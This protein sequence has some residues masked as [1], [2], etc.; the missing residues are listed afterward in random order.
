MK[1][2]KVLILFGLIV[3]ISCQS[4]NKMEYS[5]TQTTQESDTEAGIDRQLIRK[6]TIAFET[7][8]IDSTRTRIV[9]KAKKL[10]GYIASDETYENSNGGTNTIVIRLPNK[11]FEQFLETTITGTEEVLY[12]TIST[13]DV[14][15]EFLDLSARLSAKKALEK[16]Y[17]DL[18]G[19]AK[20][21]KDVLEIEQELGSI[22]SDIEASE[23]RLNFLNNQVSFATLTFNIYKSDSPVGFL[24]KIEGGLSDGWN[25]LSLFLVLLVSLWPFILVPLLVIFGIKFYRRK[26]V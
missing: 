16:R 14:T 15:E 11:K 17:I 24:S 13:E 20:T 9:D 8:D 10:G 23:G 26:K 22:R 6:G 4:N 21:V 7:G 25:Y 2:L 12:K 19:M 18:L 1:K 3:L 5:G